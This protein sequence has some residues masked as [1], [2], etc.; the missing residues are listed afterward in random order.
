MQKL[1]LIGI[2]FDKDENIEWK[3]ET[4]LWTEGEYICRQIT[5]TANRTRHPNGKV[6][7]FKAESIAEI[8]TKVVKVER[9]HL[10]YH[11][12]KIEEIEIS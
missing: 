1:K 5:D 6:D 10:E 2:I 9:E 4:L 11:C 7:R 12:D 3:R 8:Y